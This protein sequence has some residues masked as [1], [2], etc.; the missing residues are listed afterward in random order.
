MEDKPLAPD[1]YFKFM[2]VNGFHDKL[3]CV[4]FEDGTPTVQFTYHTQFNSVM[5]EQTWERTG[6]VVITKKHK[7]YL[8]TDENSNLFGDKSTNFCLGQLTI[9]DD[10]WDGTASLD[11]ETIQYLHPKTISHL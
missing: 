10:K 2:G 11:I 5:V 7:L 3:P 9:V 8:Y 1:L 6:V 4:P